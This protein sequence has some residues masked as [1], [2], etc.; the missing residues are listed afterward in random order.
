LAGLLAVA[1][2]PAAVALDTTFTPDTFSPDAFSDSVGDAMMICAAVAAL[3]GVIAFLTVRSQVA[4]TPTV[5]A[6]VNQPCHDP[7]R[8][9]AEWPAA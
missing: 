8:S 6:D 1:V 5:V 9:E 2:L 3:G 7:C 4:V